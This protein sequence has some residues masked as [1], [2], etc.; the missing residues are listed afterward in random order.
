MLPQ[1]LVYN[2][3]ILLLGILLLPSL[4]LAQVPR[5]YPGAAD[6]RTSLTITGTSGNTLVI[7]TTT[8]VVDATNHRVGIG[9]AAPV[10]PLHV[11]ETAT[12]AVRGLLVG[13]HNTAGTA[14]LILVRKSRGT[15]ASP[16]VV[17]S[18]DALG[19]LESE[20]YDGGA[21]VQ[22]ALIRFDSAGTIASTRVPSKIL[23]FTSTDAAP[24]VQTL[25]LTLGTNQSA[26]FAGALTATTLGGTGIVTALS[27]TATPAGGAQALQ[28]GTTAALG[29]YYGSGAPTISAAKGSLYI[30]SDG[31]G[32]A[33]RL[34]VNSSASTTWVA[35]TTGG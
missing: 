15:A 27:G 25:A 12:G 34:Y 21:Y 20:G 29:I 9:I 13:Q 3:S 16:T 31:T 8:L 35:V 18:G 2:K 28:M 33:D 1:Q 10:T 24:S 32:V 23:F 19:A 30:R 22:G 11:S 6:T 17:T 14:A 5:P 7:D 4:A 26:T